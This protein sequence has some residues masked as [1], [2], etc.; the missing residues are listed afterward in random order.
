MLPP[1]YPSIVYTVHT[2]LLMYCVV[3]VQWWLVYV[4]S[5]GDSIVVY[6]SK[7]LRYSGVAD[8]SLFGDGS[9]PIYVEFVTGSTGHPWDQ[10]IA[11]KVCIF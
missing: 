8:N 1:I 3:S 10:N 7:G 2:V 9:S 5:I 6:T 11:I 4:I